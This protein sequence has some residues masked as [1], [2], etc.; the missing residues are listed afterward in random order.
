MLRKTWILAGVILATAIVAAALWAM[1]R[2]QQ[3]E[4]RRLEGEQLLANL[5]GYVKVQRLEEAAQVLASLK[6]D[7]EGF[8]YLDQARYELARAY[9]A[10]GSGEKAIPLLDQVSL[11]NRTF[12]FQRAI[13][14]EKLCGL[15]SFFFDL[16]GDLR[17]PAQLDDY[18]FHSKLNPD[19]A[20][21][22]KNPQGFDDPN[23]LVDYF[24]VVA[25]QF[26]D[27]LAIQ[28]LPRSAEPA[29]VECYDAVQ[30]LLY[31]RGLIVHD[32]LKERLAA[33]A[34]GR[35]ARTLYLLGHQYFVEADYE[36]A[37]GTWGQLAKAFPS[38]KGTLRAF[39]R[40]HEL[41]EGRRRLEKNFAFWPLARPAWLD[42]LAAQEPFKAE[43]QKV[44]AKLDAHQDL[45][46]YKDSTVV[47]LVETAE[48][49]PLMKRDC[50]RFVVEA[51]V[52][53]LPP[54]D[55]ADEN[56]ERR[57]VLE[58]DHIFDWRLQTEFREF[59]IER[60]G[61][62]VF[63][64]S[65]NRTFTVKT[66]YHG[67][68]EFRA[69][70]FPDG[71][72]YRKYS[73][74]DEQAAVKHAA[75]L[76]EAAK[77][78]R[79]LGPLGINGTHETLTQEAP[80]T[81]PGFYLITARARYA[82][83][84]AT[85]Q[86]AIVSQKVL[87]W[88]SP[89]GVLFRAVDRET[90]QPLTGRRLA[91]TIKPQF[92]LKRLAP[93]FFD[94]SRSEGFMTG[95]HKAFTE[96][97]RNELTTDND[98]FMA[99]FAEGLK[100]REKYPQTPDA[101]ELKTDDK[102]L[103]QL[104]VPLKWRNEAC[105]VEASLDNLGQ[106]CPIYATCR[107]LEAADD[108]KALFYA[109]R[110]L[111]R[112]GEKARIKG[113]LRRQGNRGT[114][115]PAS[116]ELEFALWG[117]DGLLGIFRATPNAAGTVTFEA[118]L[119]ENI[120]DGACYVTMGQRQGGQ[121]YPV[122]R[123]E[124]SETPVVQVEVL[125]DT[126]LVFA[127]STVRGKVKASRMGFMAAVGLPVELK[128]YRGPAPAQPA[129]EDAREDF[130]TPVTLVDYPGGGPNDVL[131]RQI[132]GLTEV[133][134]TGGKTDAQGEYAFRFDS[135]T[136]EPSRYVIVGSVQSFPQRQEVASAQVVTLD[137]P[138][139]LDVR[140]ERSNYYPGE[141]LHATVLTRGLDSRPVSCKLRLDVER[142]DDKGAVSTRSENLQSNKEGH[143]EF[144]V[145]LGTR[146]PRIRLG[147]WGTAGWVYRD[148]RFNLRQ[149]GATAG[150]AGFT[151]QLDR[152][153]YYPGETAKLTI[154]S[155]HP[156]AS[157]LVTVSRDKV[158][159]HQDLTIAG[160]TGTIDVPVSETDTPNVFFHAVSVWGDRVQT[161]SMEIP[162]IPAQKILKV[163]IETD[164]AEYSGGEGITATLKVTD[165]RGQPVP[166]AEIS[167]GAVLS[168][169]YVMQ[170][171]LT[172]DLA[173][174]FLNHRLPLEVELGGSALTADAPRSQN[175][176]RAPVF[177]W[178]IY[179]DL[180]E[181][182]GLGGGGGGRFGVRSG[183][184]R[185]MCVRSGGSM[186]SEAMVTVYAE[187][188][189]QHGLT[190]FWEGRLVTDAR[191][192][193][194]AEFLLPASGGAF[195]FTARAIT[196]E[197]LVGEVRREIRFR[198]DIVLQAPWPTSIR[199]GEVFRQPVF[200]INGSDKTQKV[201]VDVASDF[202]AR[203]VAGNEV[204]VAPGAVARV[205]F[206]IDARIWPAALSEGTTGFV[207]AM[208]FAR[209]TAAARFGEQ[210]KVE[211]PAMVPAYPLGVCVERP[212]FLMAQAGQPA[213]QV[214]LDLQPAI[215]H[216]VSLELRPLAEP[217]AVIRRLTEEL[218]ARARSDERLVDD[219]A[220]AA[221]TEAERLPQ[222]DQQAGRALVPAAPL[223]SSLRQNNYTPSSLLALDSALRRG[224][225]VPCESAE[226]WLTLQTGQT[227]APDAATLWAVSAYAAGKPTKLAEREKLA[228]FAE[229]LRRKGSEHI[230]GWCY[231]ALAFRELDRHGKATQCLAQAFSIAGLKS[232][233]RLMTP[234][235]ENAAALLL[236]TARLDP[237]VDRLGLLHAAVLAELAASP[238][239]STWVTA[240]TVH[241]LKEWSRHW[242]KPTQAM[243]VL[244]DGK[245]RD[246][247]PDG[248]VIEY[249]AT[250]SVVSVNV[251]PPA[252]GAAV[253]EILCRYRIEPDR[254]VAEEGCSLNRTFARVD[255]DGRAERMESG[256]ELRLGDELL[257]IVESTPS[258]HWL[259]VP[260]AGPF[261]AQAKSPFAWPPRLVRRDFILSKERRARVRQAYEEKRAEDI[262]SELLAA[263]ADGDYLEET[264]GNEDRTSTT[265]T[266]GGTEQDLLKSRYEYSEV[267]AL[268]FRPDRLGSFLAPAA[269][270]ETGEG[271]PRAVAPEF[272]FSVVEADAALASRPAE[273]R[274]TDAERAAATEALRLT[275]PGFLLEQAA[276]QESD[277]FDLRPVAF[278]GILRSTAPEAYAAYTRLAWAEDGASFET[279]TARANWRS[280]LSL[281]DLA[282]GTH[283]LL[284]ATLVRQ[285]LA[286]E[287]LVD[288]IV[289]AP[290]LVEVLRTPANDFSQQVFSCVF[291]GIAK[292][293][294]SENTWRKAILA[295]A[296][297]TPAAEDVNLRLLTLAD[298]MAA[299]TPA[300]RE[301]FLELSDATRAAVGTTP[302]RANLSLHEA[303]KSW[304][305][306]RT[307]TI[308]F[309][310]NVRDLE[311]GEF[312][313]HLPDLA[314]VDALRDQ[315]K[316]FGL[317]AWRK[318]TQVT[319]ELDGTLAILNPAW[320]D[321]W[322]AK[323]AEGRLR[324]ALARQ[325]VGDLADWI[326]HLKVD[327]FSRY[328][329]RI[330]VPVELRQ[331]TALKEYKLNGR[332]L[333]E[334]FD[335]LRAQGLKFETTGGVLRFVLV[336]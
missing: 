28:N 276:G 241:A 106:V 131:A 163:A 216:S 30:I 176:W 313:L 206:E 51:E 72:S 209:F 264:E 166:N 66:S 133:W 187:F 172:P 212:A 10:T 64:P 94:G 27:V 331:E 42:E 19:P 77:W 318:G 275:P 286:D 251:E 26:E 134:S 180:I 108:W 211:S 278:G 128:V 270:L 309:A 136:R 336:K 16:A 54:T 24:N 92:D 38:D 300:Q 215:A 323:D 259:I 71:D 17:T 39:A 263:I 296:W 255:R 179:R 298:V 99:G 284:P 58:R 9:V 294:E 324:C 101:F 44:N 122:F 120:R 304:A 3:M 155:D 22:P 5:R 222:A 171:D 186:S 297:G 207:P 2:S 322:A 233:E 205:D 303:L 265:W 45:A 256:D 97:Q 281:P 6:T 288:R 142:T 181:S 55:Y 89:E 69:L 197:T 7:G 157:V 40:T 56:D 167:L 70:R 59:I 82:P 175:F 53:E 161:A 86:M 240:L 250:G 193:T 116:E 168:S 85:T 311:A 151:L 314:S 114:S 246:L 227:G 153:A 224:V 96:G 13:L 36:R 254:F 192:Q 154:Q 261:S 316:N 223:M 1:A 292:L 285:L 231:L 123:V 277:R 202:A 150:G 170:E 299:L 229:G 266:I 141:T 235:L 84:I 273:I 118:A 185:A 188:L 144:S 127:G 113:L 198:Q 68:V 8:D 201:T 217:A 14:R 317:K 43:A 93:A 41:F 67:D 119:P 238:A 327:L 315:L 335:N 32:M 237:D 306:E 135:D 329:P 182:I 121:R 184:G 260:G 269:A 115:L 57:P 196:P 325:E 210:R 104:A 60:E 130:F 139:F 138:V 312:V 117:I 15:Y 204:E 165:H 330:E 21:Q 252:Q 31:G 52:S 213:T 218:A 191:G 48:R 320:R 208:S 173:R 291:D 183:G 302:S 226:H 4:A 236:A 308:E 249:P 245:K 102:G 110:P 271:M 137:L 140:P 234:G 283:A 268:T 225:R 169:A 220:W 33:S 267:M 290:D 334:Q 219:Y 126:D 295:A 87:T 319:V 243:Q 11:H 83:V 301:A 23:K 190:L 214:K 75:A 146:A 248:K 174:Y 199:E 112:P 244:V 159:R 293:L 332:P 156:G 258:G 98:Q 62:K 262:R 272:R 253:L 109:E 200:V 79:D 78:T 124:R 274:Q 20:A 310:A 194:K 65:E 61:G 18:V 152:K 132:Q 37:F 73:G 177:A 143:A 29:L 90:G 195:R 46:R 100:L 105:V 257:M 129:P 12:E 81:E 34:T 242:Q 228:V 305:A 282:I 145:I 107:R 35:S 307:L 279:L 149:L 148:V 74:L 103:A 328:R 289:H 230:A 63:S 49:L 147:V 326:S 247:P 162:V 95:L 111:F 125:T 239:R 160:V 333:A 164:K 50:V 91:G 80:L 88:T 158:F 47:S 321:F 178:G 25:K 280:R 221:E 232:R 203:P 287:A 189:R 76:P